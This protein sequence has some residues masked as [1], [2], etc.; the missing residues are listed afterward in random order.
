MA[1]CHVL[2]R[3]FVCGWW[4]EDIRSR[5]TCLH[6]P[7]QLIQEHPPRTIS[8][9]KISELEEQLSVLVAKKEELG[10]ILDLRRKQFHLLVQCVHQLQDELQGDDVAMET[11]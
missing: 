8:R 10:K 1:V 3:D 7:S 9:D 2:G 11:S 5:K 6:T 4:L